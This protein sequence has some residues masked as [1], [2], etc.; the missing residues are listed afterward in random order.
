MVQLVGTELR[1]SI[2]DHIYAKDPTV[3]SN[4]KF[5]DPFSGDHVLI[6]F[7]V[8]ANKSNF[9]P[10]KHRD[11]RNYCSFWNNQP[12]SQFF[13]FMVFYFLG[14]LVSAFGTSRGQ[15]NQKVWII[16]LEMLWPCATLVQNYIFLPVPVRKSCVI[17]FKALLDEQQVIT[18][19]TIEI[20]LSCCEH[21]HVPHCILHLWGL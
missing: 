14:H 5:H 2:L 7:T 8:N 21:L 17:F 15:N 4:V 9:N 10:V 1:T 16:I 13:I 11:W 18:W 12:L 6:F 20:V 3:L 19:R